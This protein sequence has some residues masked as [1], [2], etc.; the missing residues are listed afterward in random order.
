MRINSLLIVL[1]F[2]VTITGCEQQTE[3]VN[4]QEETTAVENVLEKYVMAN[5]NKD[6]S[7]IEQIW[8]ED[9]D[10][11]LLGTDS[12]EKYIGWNQIK[13][14]I[15]RQFKE[16]EDTYISI[17]NQ[18]IKISEKGDAAWFSEFLNYNFIH[19]GEAK[20]FEDIRFT[21]VLE[22][23]EGIWVLVQGHLSIPA[24]TGAETQRK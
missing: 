23:R 20:S 6:F 7:L 17:T 18:K 13:K 10:I 11:I 1:I 14:A 12:H 3:K 9:D 24:D 2:I 15:Q 4:I 8:A 21:G 16:F 19:R 5:E 22:K